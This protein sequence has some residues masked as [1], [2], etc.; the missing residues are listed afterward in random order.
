MK[1]TLAEVPD[2]VI[3]EPK[4]FMDDRGW[5]MESFNEKC[6]QEGIMRLGLP[7]PNS[8]VQDNLSCSKKGVLRGLHYQLEPYT[9]G[10]LV[11]VTQ[12]AAFD[13]AV[14]IR[15]GSPTFGKWCGFHLSA[16]NKKMLWIPAGFAHGFL[17]LEDDTYFN[18]K[19]TS[20]YSK[21][22]ERSL[23]WNDPAL[24]IEWPEIDGYLVSDKDQMA[25]V[26]A[27]A[28]LLQGQW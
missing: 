4:V 5:F 2:V 25:E 13:I 1:F 7:V 27:D 16:V 10:K 23:L 14:D 18:Y 15:M 17:A 19:T 20:Y 9:Q 28:D 26:L 24:G 3:I 21:E 22:S 11:S 8:F 6:F 12:G